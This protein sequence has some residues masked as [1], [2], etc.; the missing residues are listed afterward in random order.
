MRFCILLMLASC[1]AAFAQIDTEWV[2]VGDAGNAPDKSGFGGVAYE[3]QIMKLEVTCAEYAVFLNAVAATDE[4]GLYIAKMDGTPM[5]KGRDDIRGEQGCLMRTGEKGSYRYAVSPG[6]EKK[7]IV[8]VSFSAALR[9]ANWMHGGQTE[10][11]AYDI[12]KDRAMAPRSPEA[13]VW[14]PSEN[15]WHKAAYYDASAKRYWRFATRSD[16]PPVSCKPDATQTNAANYYWVDGKNNGVSNGYAFSQSDYYK[17][18]DIYLFDVGSYPAARS[19]YGTLDQSGNVWE[20]TEGI[21]YETKRIIRGGGWA[22]EALP[23]RSTTRTSV[24]PTSTYNTVGFR[25]CRKLPK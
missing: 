6:N 8:N 23:L 9:F 19:H 12:A 11:G 4:L 15:E 16:E 21:A 7:P 20:W 25:L 2:T 1:G 10:T 18:G 5:P 22:D 24:L 14:L 17:P 3:F 13:K